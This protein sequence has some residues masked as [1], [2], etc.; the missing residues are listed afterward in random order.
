MD[1][2]TIIVA[3]EGPIS[4]N[5]IRRGNFGGLYIFC[6][7]QRHGKKDLIQYLGITER[8]FPD[9]FAQH[10]KLEII[11]QNVKC[12]TGTVV[13]PNKVNRLLLERA[14]SILIYFVQPRLNVRKKVSVPRPTSVISHWY[15]PNGAPRYNRQGVLAD[16]PDVI[17]W[18]GSNWREGNLRVWDE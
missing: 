15:K 6:G 14:E 1:H 12:W 3:W 18:D 11:T 2:Q 5:K 10:P 17:S 9:R 7:R 13:F 8:D 4:P 16:F